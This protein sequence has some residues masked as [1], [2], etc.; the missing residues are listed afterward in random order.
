MLRSGR[1]FG[2]APLFF[3]SPVQPWHGSTLL[4]E[5]GATKTWLHLTSVSSDSITQ[6]CS[7]PRHAW[8]PWGPHMQLRAGSVGVAV[9]R[10]SVR[11]LC[12]RGLVRRV[13]LWLGRGWPYAPGRPG[14]HQQRAAQAGT[15]WF[16]AGR[17]TYNAAASELWGGAPDAGTVSCMTYGLLIH[18]PVDRRCAQ[19]P[20]SKRGTLPSTVLP[21]TPVW[22]CC[23]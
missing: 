3:M 22:G 11:L 16:R 9:H 19:V 5:P 21:K 10:M 12:S 6:C 1:A 20:S 8:L 2:V 18:C 7:Q 15:W 17:S 23:S 13:G 4:H 14:V